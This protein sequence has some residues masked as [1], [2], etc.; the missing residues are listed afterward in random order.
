MRSNSRQKESDHATFNR[1]GSLSFGLVNVPVGLNPATTD[2]T[3]RFHQMES[4]NS[5]RIRH[6]KVNR[7]IPFRTVDDRA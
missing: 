1:K 6:K 7:S 4:G 2:K 3:L 5:D